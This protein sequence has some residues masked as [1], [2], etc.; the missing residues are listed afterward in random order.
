MGILNIGTQALQAN[1]VALQTIG[2]N[3]ANVNTVGYS[4]QSVI[5]GTVA[6]QFTGA[7][8]IGKGVDIQT[9]QRNYDQFLTRQSTLAAS[10]QSAD[11]TRSNYLTQ[12]SNIF[13][14]GTNGIGQSVNDMLN[15]MSDVAST[16]TDITARTVVL[17]RVDETTRRLRDASQSLDDL[18]TG[19]TQALNEKISTV[20]TLAQ[21][22]ADVNG[23]IAL[24]K[25]NGQPPNDLLDKRDQLIHDINQYVQTTSVAADDG[26]VGIYIGG[27]QSL[28][29]GSSASK[30]ALLA[31]KNDFG[32]PQQ[33]KLTVTRD[34]LSVTM[35]ENVLGG[36]E[37][38]GLLRFQ[39]N[40]LVESRNLL[41][42]LTTAITTTLNT[43]HKLGLDLNGNVGQNLFTPVSVN[44]I[45]VP[46]A[47]ATTNGSP[48]AALQLGISDASQFVASDYQ[49][50]VLSGTQVAVTR[51]SDGSTR[52]FD[53]TTA[54]P[55]FDG[56]TLTGLASATTGDRFL[57]KPFASAAT[58]IAREF[59]TP[60][61]LAVASPIVGKM[62]ASNTGSL[63]LASLRAN[64]NPPA[65]MPVIV[66][67]DT[68]G[69][70][71]KYSLSGPGPFPN[72]TGPFT[73]TSGQPIESGDNP[74]AWTLTLQGAPQ[75]GD[76]FTVQDIK[77][78]NLD[79]KLNGGNAT[80]MLNLRDTTMFDGA[81]MSDGYAGLISQIGIRA[82]SA[83]YSATVSTNI[84]VNA[85]KDRT[86]IAGV[87]LD[88]EAAKLI[89][90]QQAYQASAKMIQVAQTIFTTLIQTLGG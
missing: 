66:T 64:I 29:L 4:R 72:G 40:D 9:I 15:S 37:V 38:S 2:N 51:M 63:Q 30:L 8:Y 10:T 7:G 44:N 33:N 56:L 31:T 20:N 70:P 85:E 11:T 3:I 12:L 41:G 1:Q 67:F 19:I 74:S 61:A 13:Q 14:G 62:G 25:G 79:I 80:N 48:A 43:Q 69:S 39:N 82:Q 52:T 77:S 60:S 68:T 89:Q 59:S 50:K 28:V 90:Y 83:N 27:S 18:Q 55:T 45:L 36:G 54:D 21:K 26:T 88:E 17:T 71:T 76:S 57:L 75:N 65:N 23:Q 86:G 73:Y 81:A 35:D 42:R 78:T 24:A 22:I 34:G 5:M 84:A 87:N 16:P 49:V 46:V 32:D 6:G 47:P 53:P 58:N